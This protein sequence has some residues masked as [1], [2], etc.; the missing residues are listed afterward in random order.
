MSWFAG[1]PPLVTWWTLINWRV[2]SNRVDLLSKLVSIFFLRDANHYTKWNRVR[3]FEQRNIVA[4]DKIFQL[5]ILFQKNWHCD[6]TRGNYVKIFFKFNN[7][8]FIIVERKIV[9]PWEWECTDDYD[10]IFW[11]WQIFY[12]PER[13]FKMVCNCSWRKK[14][15]LRSNLT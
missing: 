6:M 13:I 12:C 15:C 2:I 3:I 14:I 11:L 8:F 4:L 5:T 1:S 9:K 7:T 10:K